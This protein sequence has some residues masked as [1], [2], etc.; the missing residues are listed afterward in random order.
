MN[1][2]LKSTLLLLF[3]CSGFCV[4][5]QPFLVTGKVT[6]AKD[7]SPLT[8]AV[9][10]I[11]SVADTNQKAGAAAD[12]DGNFLVPGIQAGSYTLQVNFLGYTTV[13]RN[14]L[15]VDANVD[16]GIIALQNVAK[17]LKAVN[18]QGSQIRAEQKEDTSQFKADAYKTNPDATAEDLVGKMPGITSDGTGVKVNG[19]TVQQVL[20]DGKPFFGSDPSV[21][22]KN[23]PAEVIDKIQVFD[24]LSDQSLFTGFDDGNTQKTMNIITK[25]NKSEGYFGKVYAGYGTSDRYLAGGNLNIFNGDRRISVLGLFNNVNQ[26]NFSAEDILGATGGS[27]GGR[28]GMRGGG[29]PRGGGGNWGNNA[30]SN[31]MVGQQ[32]GIT[33]TNAVGVNYSDNWGK[34]VKITASY[35]FNNTNNSRNDT[36]TRNYFISPEDTIV[37]NE[38]SSS[39]AINSNHRFNARMEYN[40]DSS[41]SITFTPA[42]SLQDNNT[43]SNTNAQNSMREVLQSLTRTENTAHSIGY[44]TSGNIL[45]QH[46]FGKPRRTI[47]LNANGSLNERDGNG[48]IYAFNDFID[49]TTLRDQHYDLYGNGYNVSG[50]LTYTEPVG[51]SG[52]LMFSYNPSYTQNSSDKRT[53]T[54]DASGNDL[55]YIDTTFSSVYDN[56][57]TTQKGGISYRIGDRGSKY[58]F[59]A[60]INVQ[61]AVLNSEQEFPRDFSISRTFNNVLPNA[62]FNR[63]YDG[64]K[65]LRVM[66]RTATNLPSVSQMQNVIDITNPLLLR[67]GNAELE[68]TYEHTLIVRYGAANQKTARNFFVNLYLNATQDYIGTATYIPRNDSLYADPVTRTSFL[69]NRGGQLSR[70]VN[71]DGYLNGRLFVTYGVPLKSI[72]SNL[73]TNAGFN[74]SR[75]PGLINNNT[76]YSGNYIPTAGLVLS[77]NISENLDFTLSYTANYNIV[78]NTIQGAG[79]NNFYNH[80]ASAR[81]NWIFLKNFVFNTNI[82]NNY[83]TAFSSTGD[84]SFLLWNTYVGYKFFKKALEARVSVYDL[85]NQNTSISRTV[86]E[87]YIENANT[88]VL[89]QYFMFQLTYTVRNFKSGVPPEMSKQKDGTEPPAGNDFRRR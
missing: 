38:Y 65:N 39:D 61:Q 79:S 7:K 63:R 80:V 24:K 54:R 42:L 77:S 67:T 11:I 27:G 6:D 50:N 12:V 4:I 49:T 86:T 88:Q 73:N 22:L 29:G 15:V 5:A 64:G 43:G 16:A 9:V 57:Y 48:T 28:G 19:E 71:L 83:Y 46:K 18:V 17:E 76:N 14:I 53:R 26:Q 72:K 70:P 56:S 3:S 89:K 30:G 55:P 51:K 36:V 40:I 81:V 33:A 60:G 32:G 45:Y 74:Y 58:H 35:F 37:Y 20:V 52:Q 21:A 85:L 1:I 87:T 69:I 31:F 59:N 44:N 41:N 78:N 66:Y 23:L 62:S 75:I 82:T 25:R 84:Q 47:S 34:K 10:Q 68:Q 2:I 8:G 13:R